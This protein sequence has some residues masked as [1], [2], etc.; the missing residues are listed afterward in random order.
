M[1]SRGGNRAVKARQLQ[2]SGPRLYVGA[3][4]WQPSDGE[5]GF[6]EAKRVPAIVTEVAGMNLSNLGG[7]ALWDGSEAVGNGEYQRVVKQALK[8]RIGGSRG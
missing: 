8:E 3:F 1:A 6:L 2:G 5:T 7:W 4:G